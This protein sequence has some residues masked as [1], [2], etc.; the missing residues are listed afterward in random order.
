M[1]LQGQKG[2]WETVVGTILIVDDEPRAVVEMA[3]FFRREGIE[4]V[5]TSD[6]RKALDIVARDEGLIGV[7]TDLKMRGV[8]GL[9]ILAAAQGRHFPFVAAITGHA[10]EADERKARELGAAYFF[11]KP[12]DLRA[13][14]W[15][16]KAAL[17]P[18]SAAGRP[19]EVSHG[20]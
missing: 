19:E 18:P 5:E 2:D 9:E 15:D 14:L 7:I 10:T 16:L 1:T 8:D 17:S 11:P 6:S 4:I 12:L 20:T 13:I 3:A